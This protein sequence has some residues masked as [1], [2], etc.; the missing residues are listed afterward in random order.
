MDALK[1]AQLSGLFAGM[2]DSQAT[3]NPAQKALTTYL[4]GSAQSAI[5]AEAQK[6]AQ[7][8]AKKKSSGIGGLLGTVGSLVA[9]PFTG[10][11]SLAYLPAAAAAGGVV[12]SAINKD[13]TG[14][15]TNAANAGAGAYGAY[16]ASAVPAYQSADIGTP[17][18]TPE[19][20]MWGPKLAPDPFAL[21]SSAASGVNMSLP[22]AQAAPKA[23]MFSNMASAPSV[24]INTPY[25]PA[26][27]S[28]AEG[29][30][31]MGVGRIN[32][33]KLT[34]SAFNRAQV[35]SIAGMNPHDLARWAHSTPGAAGYLTQAQNAGVALT[36]HQ[37]RRLP[38]SVKYDMRQAGNSVPGPMGLYS[39]GQ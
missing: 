36:P 16:K 10:G 18:P 37:L 32:S 39:W 15:I 34:G 35:A 7:K 19:T 2:A 5:A 6:K 8:K 31:S 25:Q 21:D 3:F 23:S 1:W 30:S 26:A 24:N 20:S 33:D 13:L 38:P 11:A 29:E 22:R 12:D 9:A 27:S 14:A 28:E 4:Q 17:A